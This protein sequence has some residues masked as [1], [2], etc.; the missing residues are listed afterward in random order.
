MVRVPV[1]ES[2]RRPYMQKQGSN[3]NISQNELKQDSTTG[4]G[5]SALTEY[6]VPDVTPWIT[7]YE[8]KTGSFQERYGNTTYNQGTRFSIINI[9]T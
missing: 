4:P 8:E 9:R 1:G 7:L 2:P 3:E 5:L 6:S